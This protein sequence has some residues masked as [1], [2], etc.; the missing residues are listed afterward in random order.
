VLILA[1]SAWSCSETPVEGSEDAA[2]Q[3]SEAGVQRPDRQSIADSGFEDSGALLDAEP[4]D[5][6]MLDAGDA[7]I[8]AAFPDAM[9]GPLIEVGTGT[10]MFEAVQ[11]GGRVP[12][13]LGPQGGGSQGGYHLWMA[14]RTKDF[15]PDNIMLSVY[16]LGASDR[17]TIVNMSNQLTLPSL[18][19][20]YYG[21]TGIRMMPPDCCAVVDE[22]M[23][24]RVEL[25]DGT[26]LNG[27]GELMILGGDRCPDL[28]DNNIC[29]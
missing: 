18:G 17:R 7:P 26:G 12:F 2:Q 8:D 13:I 5:R 29:P 6:A 23:I 24:M 20:G 14:F 9:A 22:P 1:L 21:L 3:T 16:L 11:A 25:T 10:Q 15:R 28:D 27:V 4:D 19:G